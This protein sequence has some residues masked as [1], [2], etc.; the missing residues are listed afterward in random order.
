MRTNR[1]T[2]SRKD[3]E[4]AI[5]GVLEVGARSTTVFVRKSGKVAGKVRASGI[6]KHGWGNVRLTIGKLNY[7]ERAY[8]KRHP[9]DKVWMPL[10]GKK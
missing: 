6:R 2:V 4:T 9:S 1:F 10:P 5:F 3:V 7:A 8:N